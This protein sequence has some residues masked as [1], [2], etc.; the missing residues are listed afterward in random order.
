MAKKPLLLLIGVLA[1]QV[2][3]ATEEITPAVVNTMENIIP[4]LKPD[5]VD[6]SPIPGVY[7]VTF[8]PHIVYVTSDGRYMLR[9]DVVDL[10]KR[11]NLTELKRQQAR[12]DVI[13]S[14]D[15]ARMIVFGPEK[16]KYTVTVFTDITCPYC[17]Q[18]HRQMSEYND[19]GV[20]IRYL[21]YPR[22][23]VPSKPYVDM[24]SVWCADDPQKAMTDAKAGKQVPT[25]SCEN[26]VADHYKMGRELGITGTPTLILDNGQIVPGYVPPKRLIQMLESSES[27]LATR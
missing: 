7:E 5:R 10:K 3:T 15:E 13:N 24:V 22:A 20:K 19:A 4:G 25:K 1:C 18:L 12:V 27:D 17:Q 23:G 2:A 6:H 11:E 8:G 14:L 9:G 26:P 16:A 21:A